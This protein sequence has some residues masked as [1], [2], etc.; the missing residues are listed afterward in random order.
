MKRISE[1][2]QGNNGKYSNVR[3]MAFLALCI[4]GYIAIASLYL[5]RMDKALLL[6]SAFI[7]AAFAGKVIQQKNEKNGG[8]NAGNNP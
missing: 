8:D 4:A 3:L 7:G 5:D 2:F 6:V 1:F